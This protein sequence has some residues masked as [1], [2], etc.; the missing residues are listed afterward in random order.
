[1]I[2]IQQTQDNFIFKLS[3][4]HQIWAL[5]SSI[6]VPKKNVIRAYQ[7]Q[8]ELHKFPGFRLG[9]HIPF[10]ITAGTYFLRGKQNFWDVMVEKNAVIVELQNHIFTKLYIQVKNPQET[11]QL[12]NSK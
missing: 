5:K 2:T 11:L 6:T 4:F 10:L 3:G 8:Q 9:T 1:M 7:D 12:L